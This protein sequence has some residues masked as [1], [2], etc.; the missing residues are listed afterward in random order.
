M[1]ALLNTQDTGSTP[2]G[3]P[4]EPFDVL[5]ECHSQ[6]VTALHQMGHL[7]EHLQDQ[8]VDGKA[9][10]MARDIFQFFMNTARQHHLD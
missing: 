5:D 6:L 10:K 1:S 9:Q 2:R 4:I 7:V 3:R 8:G